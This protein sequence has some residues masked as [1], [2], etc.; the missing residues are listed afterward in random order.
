M[1]ISTLTK[2]DNFM[3]ALMDS[4]Q[5]SDYWPVDL[6][7][8][9]YIQAQL[10]DA[11]DN[12]PVVL[13]FMPQGSTP[14][15]GHTDH[16]LLPARNQHAVDGTHLEEMY[17]YGPGKGEEGTFVWYRCGYGAPQWMVIERP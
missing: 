12:R 7:P 13:R 8:M 16:V 5:A 14:P 3:V 17:V 10:W 4:A 9:P 6:L 1:V 11:F 2:Y 15:A